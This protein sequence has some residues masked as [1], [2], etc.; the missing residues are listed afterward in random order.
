MR[1]RTLY[2]HLDLSSYTVFSHIIS[3]RQDFF[4]KK[5]LN[6]QCVLI[7]SANL[8]QIFLSKK[9][10]SQIR[11]KLRRTDRDM[12]K[13]VYQSSRTETVILVLFKLNLD[14]I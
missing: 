4:K 13:N 1:M 3:K 8:S 12:V 11:S 14:F 2:L 5:L 7:F 9:K 10:L 6:M